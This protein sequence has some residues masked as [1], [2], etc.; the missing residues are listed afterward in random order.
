MVKEDKFVMPPVKPIG[1]MT[2]KW[3]N[4][5]SVEQILK[6]QWIQNGFC[7]LRNVY[8][9]SEINLYNQI[10]SK[11]RAQVDDGKDEQGFGD[12]IG[13]LHQ[14]YPDLLNLAIEPRVISF[15]K[16]AFNDDPVV[17]G[18]LN[19]EKGTQQDAH[20]DA[21]FFWPEPSYS[22]CGCWVA[23][24]DI[25]P[26]S[27][28]LFYVPNS[29]NWPFLRSQDIVESRPELAERRIAA[30]ESTTSV[31]ERAKIVSELGAAWTEEFIKIEKKMRTERPQISLKAGDV[32]FWHSLLAH[33]GSPRLDLN[34]SRK[35]VVFHYIGKRT[36]LFTFEQFMLYNETELLMQ[37]PQP[38]N[39][40][41]FKNIEYMRYQYFV[42]YNSS[43]QTVHPL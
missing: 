30:R 24:E 25:H 42:T 31:E 7:I 41:R 5:K 8:T 27:G 15:L 36:R 1:P 34:L 12:R 13:Q 39:L 19:F 23:L 40:K 18:S 6:D 21:I 35:S 43:G 38:M 11:V 3:L 10:I 16:W 4:D 2:D 20:I 29:H 9:S 22:M 14:K 32:V 33:G 26:N 17:F 28:P 37:K